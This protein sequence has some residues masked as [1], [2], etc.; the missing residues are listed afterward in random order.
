MVPRDVE[1]TS[2]KPHPLES[3]V[4]RQLDC[5]DLDGEDD[6]GLQEI[7]ANDDVISEGSDT[8]SMATDTANVIK[9][10]P[11]ATVSSVNEARRDE[12]VGGQSQSQS[13]YR[14]A[15]KHNAV[16][17]KYSKPFEACL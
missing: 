12:R 3:A 17:G 8:V 15:G 11:T 4:S 7:R 14:E 16:D 5:I 9:R 13:S 1:V 2:G 6:W 10:R